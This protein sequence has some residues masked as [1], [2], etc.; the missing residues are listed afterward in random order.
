MN[1]TIIKPK[2]RAEIWKQIR[3]HPNHYV[4][5]LGGVKSID[6]IVNDKGR[7]SHRKGK[8]FH[9]TV[10]GNGYI[11]VVVEKKWYSVHRLVAMTFI[12][13]I[14]GKNMVNHKNGIKTDNRVENL[15]WV[16]ASE[17]V[18]H[19]HAT[20]LN[21]M[22]AEG[23]KRLSDMHKGMKLSDEAKRKLLLHHAKG[24]K[25]SEETKQK[26]SKSIKIWHNEK[27]INIQ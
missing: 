16:T 12:P 2:D 25:H 1:N 11:R 6:H 3:G 24:Y 13:Q 17:N 22:T 9:L 10:S 20:G 19:A 23:R 14:E 27:K 26:I 15:E 18:K 8:I 5:N 4:S 7:P 21:R